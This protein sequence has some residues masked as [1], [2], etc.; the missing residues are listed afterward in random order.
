MT[1]RVKD[2]TL[3]Q[4]L[5]ELEESLLQPDV[6]KSPRLSELLADDFL[7]F[8]STGRTYAKAD[9][10]AALAA[11]IRVVQTTS[12]FKVAMVA[13]HVALVTYRLE[14]HAEPPVHTRRSSL[15]QMREGEW[16]MV[17][18]QATVIPAPGREK[19]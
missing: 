14:K 4:H 8:A 10:V 18:H 15:W 6:R 5:Q 3:A 19:A 7:E 16:K 9:L 1:P 17:F 11:E 2:E 13:P 12:E